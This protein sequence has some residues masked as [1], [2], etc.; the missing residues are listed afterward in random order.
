MNSQP[1][2]VL[3]IEEN[4]SRSSPI[5]NL[6][7]N[8][9]PGFWSVD[10][11]DSF[12]EGLERLPHG[13]YN[14]IL[15]DLEG[16]SLDYVDQA[17]ERG[18]LI[19][20]II[21][22]GADDEELAIQAMHQGAQDYLVKDQVT[23]SLL[24]RSI[25][26]AIER[27][28]AEL[29]LLQAEE[30]YRSIF[31]NTIEGIF[32]T[33]PDGRYLS[34]NS[35]LA[36]IYGYD[37]P[38]TLMSSL[39]DIG[40][41]LYVEPDRRAAFIELMGRHNLVTNF[42]SR[43][44][45]SDGSIIWVSENVRAVRD[46]QGS[47]LFYEGTVE[48]ITERKMAEEKVRNSE[49]LYHSL[50]ENLPQHIFRKDLSERFTFANH[51]FCQALG[52]PLEEII[53]KT[54]FDFFPPELAAKYQRDDRIILETGK[55][56]ETIEEHQPPGSDKM[57]VNVVK[58]PLYD[59]QGNISGLQGIFWDITEK[60]RTEERA[61]KASS[62]LA[63]SREELRAKNEEMEEDLL[64]AREFQ[65]AILPQQYPV[66]PRNADP[67]QSRIRFCHR[68][69]PTGAVG[70]DFFNLMALSDTQ[71]GIFICDVMGHGVRSALVTAIMRALVEELMPVASDPGKLLAQCNRDLRGIL[72]QT[73]ATMFTTA[74]YLVVDLE[75]Q[76]LHYANAGHP[77]PILLRR[78]GNEVNWLSNS[79]GISRPALGLFDD[80]LY[81]T[82][83]FPLLEEDVVMLFTDG[84]YDVDG[85]DQ[86]PCSPEW[87]LQTTEKMAHLP[88]EQLFDQLLDELRRHSNQNDF[89][90][91]VCLVGIEIMPR[92]NGSFP[93]RG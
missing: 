78:R 89:I 88:P 14:V 84:I 8:A 20:I 28:Q 93:A 30:K 23:H 90:D 71:A 29:A 72:K 46:G 36:R 87:L 63:R 66:F 55:I 4:L 57:Y 59:S 25:R 56:F 50:V 27:K 13:K 86:Q 83:H 1:I 38:E 33:S 41:K 42:E 79:D 37:S 54:D 21:L 76:T 10:Q 52:K 12:A 75:S 64:M 24:L 77:K 44:Y 34:A 85:P 51:R 26:Y 69:F 31:E 45:R 92:P 60:K 6:L 43:I 47:L 15:L 11:A 18:P 91:D 80:S 61:Q 19:P 7:E 67:G 68:Y 32:Q 22:S 16:H 35:A 9:A 2:K 49:N 81:A 39:T 70:G 74:V 17:I 40:R 48:D 58:T 73:G 5:R 3:L 82:S 53:G 65:Q 62:E